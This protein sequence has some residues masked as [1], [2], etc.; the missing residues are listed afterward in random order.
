[1]LQWL[2]EQR[3][4]VTVLDKLTYAGNLENLTSIERELGWRP[5]ETFAS[6]LRKTIE[7]Y[8]GNLEWVE[9]VTSGSYREWINL[10]YNPSSPVGDAKQ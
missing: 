4:P 1:V 8:L 2:T 6:G 7:W 5:R 9:H 10:Q 3:A